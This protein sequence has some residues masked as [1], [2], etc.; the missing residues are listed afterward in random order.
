MHILGGLLAVLGGLVFVL[1]RMQQAANSTRDI[2][3]AANEAHSLFRRWGWRRKLAKNP[4][5]TVTDSREA[6]AAMMVAAAQYDGSLT[7][8]ERVAILAACSKYFGATDQQA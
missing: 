8:R 1:W 6:A 4:L 7:E 2:A 3:D 5:D